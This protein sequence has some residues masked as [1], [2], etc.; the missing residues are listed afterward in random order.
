VLH[1]FS[2]I[3]THIPDQ[4]NSILS[5]PLSEVE[6]ICASN[7]SRPA[8]QR[9]FYSLQLHPWHLRSEADIEAFVSKAHELRDDPQL[10]AIGECGLDS[11]C[12]TP[13]P[14]QQQAF[15]AALQIA[16]QLGLPVIIHCVKLWAEMMAI[17]KDSQLIT[18]NY[19][20]LTLNPSS[21]FKGDRGGLSSPLIIHG[22]RKGPQLARQ[23]FDAGF[24]ISVGE[25][26]NPEVVNIISPERLYHETDATKITNSPL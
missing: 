14:L 16:Q 8:D 25:H 22:F 21:P 20:P 23:L 17:V 26:Y 4:P 3:H 5:I 12:A 18:T 15:R 1:R 7:A 13:L 19:L 6:G 24:S 10:V 9:Q 11:L 2:D